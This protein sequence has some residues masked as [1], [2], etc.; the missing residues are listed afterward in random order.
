MVIRPITIARRCTYC[1]YE[2]QPRVADPKKCPKCQRWQ[3]DAALQ[4]LKPFARRK[5]KS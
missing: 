4:Q 5:A 2:W 1:R 3:D